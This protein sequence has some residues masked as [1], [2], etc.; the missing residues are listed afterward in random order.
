M[1]VFNNHLQRVLV[2]KVPVI[3]KSQ[4]LSRYNHFSIKIGGVSDV[5][6]SIFSNYFSMLSISNMK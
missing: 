4:M 6:D 2:L 3:Y 5:L 1:F